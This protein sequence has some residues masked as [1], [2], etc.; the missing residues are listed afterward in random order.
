MDQKIEHSPNP[1]FP[2]SLHIC[3]VNVLT[4]EQTAEKDV[5]AIEHQVNFIL[6]EQKLNLLPEMVLSCFIIIVSH[7]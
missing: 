2:K 5:D 3:R 6:L 1:T 4:N 7:F